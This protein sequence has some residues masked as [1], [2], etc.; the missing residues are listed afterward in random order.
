M[1]GRY[2]HEAVALACRDNIAGASTQNEVCDALPVRTRPE[3]YQAERPMRNRR[4]RRG[5]DEQQRKGFTSHQPRHVFKDGHRKA[6]GGDEH[7]QR[8][9]GQ[10]EDRPAIRGYSAEDRSAWTLRKLVEEDLGPGLAQAGGNEIAVPHRNTAAQE[11]GVANA[12]RPSHRVSNALRIVGNMLMVH[13][14]D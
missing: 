1:L 10:P 9:A 5:R 7:G 14:L 6:P 4:R 2:F 8:V 12:Q 3:A 13:R 11:H